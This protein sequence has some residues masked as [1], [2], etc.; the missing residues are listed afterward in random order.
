MVQISGGVGVVV[1][2]LL[3]FSVLAGHSIVSM[4]APQTC[5]FGPSATC[6]LALLRVKS[7]H[8]PMYL[9]SNLSMKNRRH[10]KS[11]DNSIEIFIV[12]T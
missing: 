3:Q 6:Q 10:N 9:D 7:E 1:D 11:L 5:W 12:A 4:H 8:W 2:D